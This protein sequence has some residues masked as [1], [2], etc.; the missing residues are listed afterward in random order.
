MSDW[1]HQEID[2]KASPARIYEAYMDSAQHAAFTANGDAEISRVAGGTFSCHGGAILGRNVELVPNE[3]IVQAWRVA[4]W[5]DGVYSI[6]RIELRPHN[7]GT[8]IILDH[9]GFPAEGGE[10]LDSGWHERYWQPLRKYLG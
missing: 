1:I 6:V 8:R 5:E 2:F 7:G 10:H 4:N 3:R 9:A